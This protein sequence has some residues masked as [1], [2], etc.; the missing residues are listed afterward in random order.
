MA[1][2][3]TK[4]RPQQPDRSR[5]QQG[6][7]NGPSNR[8]FRVIRRGLLKVVIWKN[9]TTNG[10]MFSTQLI[11]VYKDGE[12]WK[13]THSF[14]REDLLHAA[15][16]ST[17]RIQSSTVKRKTHANSKT[18]RLEQVTTLHARRTFLR[19]RRAPP[20]SQLLSSEGVCVQ[21]AT[22]TRAKSVFPS[23]RTGGPPAESGSRRHHPRPPAAAR[24]AA[25]GHESRL[26]GRI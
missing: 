20:G 8:P 22:A 25:S 2:T 13:E 26:A 6:Q 17:R 7:T 1:A 9:Q 18:D 19:P 14:N 15:K 12:D 11:R 10:S 23:V 4:P 3:A 5:Q 24:S 21:A 16:C